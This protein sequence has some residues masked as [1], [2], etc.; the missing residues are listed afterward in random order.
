MN[1]ASCY[2]ETGEMKKWLEFFLA[3]YYLKMLIILF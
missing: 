3:I 1:I 2:L